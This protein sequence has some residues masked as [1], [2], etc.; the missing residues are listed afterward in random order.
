[1][2]IHAKSLG[3]ITIHDLFFKA[4]LLD[5]K[6]QKAIKEHEA[7]FRRRLERDGFLDEFEKKK[8]IKKMKKVQKDLDNRK[9]IY[10]KFVESIDMYEK[11]SSRLRQLEKLGYQADRDFYE[12]L[13]FG[14]VGVLD[15]FKRRE[16]L[17]ERRGREF[18]L[19]LK[20]LG[21]LQALDAYNVYNMRRK[22]F[23]HYVRF[24]FGIRDP[25]LI[26]PLP[27][28]DKFEN[29]IQK[30]G[31]L[32]KYARPISR[33][34]THVPRSEASGLAANSVYYFEGIR[35]EQKNEFGVDLGDAKKVKLDTSNC[36]YQMLES[37]AEFIL[38]KLN[39]QYL[40]PS[41]FFYCSQSVT[42]L[43]LESK[44]G[45]A[46]NPSFHE[47]AL[48]QKRQRPQPHE[49]V[50]AGEPGEAGPEPADQVPELG[51]R[52]RGPEQEPPPDPG[53]LPQRSPAPNLREH[54]HQG[55]LPRDLQLGERHGPVQTAERQ[56]QQNQAGHPA[57]LEE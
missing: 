9:D 35:V 3:N 47:Q 11:M 14:A 29:S 7:D 53:R 46:P 16:A 10:R 48:E 30:V 23:Q 5:K 15:E 26:P 44:R 41:M 40:E 12:S 18:R 6:T 56:N 34:D 22:N 57:A 31:I 43:E 37:I 52:L 24:C 8:Y 38:D 28:I 4:K 54:E 32:K 20:R 36:Q 21:K 33:D 1:M 27:K 55:G 13:K 17:L 49:A 50:R 51:Q 42:F 45:A 2:L 19:A 25:N 39:F